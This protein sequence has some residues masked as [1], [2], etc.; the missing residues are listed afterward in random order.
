MM[1]QA[2]QD[3]QYGKSKSAPLQEIGDLYLG[4]TYTSQ[5]KAATWKSIRRG[6]KKITYPTKNNRDK[7]V[8]TMMM[9]IF[10]ESH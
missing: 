8:L 1:A 9:R 10:P 5:A 4:R 7:E 6:V 2:I 3:M